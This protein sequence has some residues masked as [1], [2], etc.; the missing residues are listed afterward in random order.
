MPMTPIA[1]AELASIQ[2][3]ITATL[4]LDCTIQR[5]PSTTDAYGS[6]G[7]GTYATIATC[8]AGMKQPGATL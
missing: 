6:P 5:R 3:D 4:N 1:P 7:S 8:K 2:A